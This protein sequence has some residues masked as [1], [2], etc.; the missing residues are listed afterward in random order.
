MVRQS[1]RAWCCCAGRADAHRGA[2][3]ECIYTSRPE[4]RIIVR[5]IK[6][7]P[8]SAA[9]AALPVAN[10][11]TQHRRHFKLDYKNPYRLLVATILS[12][13]S[14]DVGVNRITPA[15]FTRYPNAAL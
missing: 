4:A 10:S 15:L 5:S 14:T 6:K 8:Q 7:S 13:Q 3:G 2:S 11:C 1:R 9:E 12:A